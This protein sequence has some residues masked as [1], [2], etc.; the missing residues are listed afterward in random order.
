MLFTDVYKNYHSHLQ[1][2]DRLFLNVGNYQYV[3][4]NIREEGRFTFR[5]GRSLKINRRLFIN[6]TSNSVLRS[7]CLYVPCVLYHRLRHLLK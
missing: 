3:L 7:L 6:V 2:T 4:R 1:G 5:R